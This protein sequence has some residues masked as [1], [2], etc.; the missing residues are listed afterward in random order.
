MDMNKATWRK[1]SYSNDNGALCIELAATADLVA[2][3]DSKSPETG[4]IPLTRDTFRKLSATI[5]SL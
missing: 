1:S 3:R 2:V 4:H 5:K